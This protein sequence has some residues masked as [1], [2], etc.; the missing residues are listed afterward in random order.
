VWELDVEENEEGDKGHVLK[1]WTRVEY[2]KQS[3]DELVLVGNGV[4]KGSAGVS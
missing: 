2:Q 1:T 4:M 3:G